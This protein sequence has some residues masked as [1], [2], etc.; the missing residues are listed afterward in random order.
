METPANHL[1]PEKFAIKAKEEL[2]AAGVDIIARDLNWIKEQKMGSFMSVSQGSAE[3]PV[4]LEM[5][6]NNGSPDQNPIVYVGKGVTFD[7]GG[8]SLKPSKDMDK[9]RGDM[10]GAATVTG[11]MYTAAHLNMPVNFK[12]LI[13]LCE[14]MPGSRATKPGDVVT[15]KNGKTIQVDNTDAEG[16]LILADALTYADTF[17]PQL[18]LD[19]A[20]LTGAMAVAIGGAASGV[21]STTD[22]NWDLIQK[23]SFNT[24][25]RVWRMPL[26]NFYTKQMQKCATADL[27]NIGGSPYGGSCTA[28]AFL[29]EFVECP[30]WMHL[31]IA[32]V[33]H[34]TADVDYLPAGMAGRP[35]RTLVEFLQLLRQEGSN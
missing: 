20:T 22:Q 26:W 24:G 31:D 10:G 8:I 3:N 30:Q 18:V 21:Y 9:M 7:T 6:I 28:A 14:N 27:N 29:K 1:T 25:D 16:R 33:M 19:V 12:V 13:P 35:T 11:A 17:K 34:N 23:A 5:S 4:F 2:E 32:G 15:A